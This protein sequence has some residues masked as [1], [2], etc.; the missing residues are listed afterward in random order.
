MLLLTY[1]RQF[2]KDLKKMQKRGKNLDKI[3]FIIQELACERKLA[4]CFRD[5]KLAGNF[6]GRRECHIEPNWLII[7]KLTSSEI[8]FERTGSHPDLFKK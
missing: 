2:Q 8:I 4:D 5:H 7:Y 3:K 1:T 6:L